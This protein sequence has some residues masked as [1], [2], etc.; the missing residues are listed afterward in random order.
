MKK[1]VI[2]LTLGAMLVAGPAL[3]GV[4]TI[5]ES[6]TPGAFADAD[7]D[8]RRMT[9]NRTP[10]CGAF[11]NMDQR[12]V[13]VLIERYETLGEALESGVAAEIT[14]A[15]QSLNALVTAN[16]RFE[17]CWDV[18]ARKQDISRKLKREL[19]KV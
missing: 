13:D 2:L 18:I 8:W 3:A 1:P 4:E 11:G 5:K 12:R 10:D 15:A 14:E 6:Y 19:R 7:Y 16:S 9:A 17:T